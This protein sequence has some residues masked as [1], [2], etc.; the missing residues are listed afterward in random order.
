VAAVF[1]AEFVL[2]LWTAPEASKRRSALNCRLRYVGSFLGVVD[3]VVVV[4]LCLEQIVPVERDW[5]DLVGLLPLMKLA[6]FMPGLR[7]V[8]TVVK[9]EL[10]PLL[11]ALSVLAVLLV[12]VSGGMYVI[13]R[14]AQPAAFAS[15]PHALWWGIVT[16]GTIGYGDVVPITAGGKIFASMVM[17]IG[18]AIFGIPAGIMANGFASE[19]K[20]RDYLV[21]WRSLSRV[22]LFQGLDASQI[23]EIARLVQVQI[24]PSESVI[25]RKGEP[26]DAMYFI[27]EGSVEVDVLPKPVTLESGQFFGEVGLIKDTVRNAT[28]T[29]IEELRLLALGK[30]D[31][32]RLMKAFPDLAKRIAEIAAGRTGR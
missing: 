17:L 20:R 26:A 18:V 31:F 16:M 30:S 19:I 4:P 23:A 2:R 1:T 14:E 15:I 6:R 3:L 28:V 13:E 24:A 7:L 21:T 29:A 10:R 27:L 25:V 8:G 32:Q 5:I 22:P 11:A 12:L 9:N